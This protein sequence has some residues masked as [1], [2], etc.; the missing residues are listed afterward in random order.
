MT[1][2]ITWDDS[3]IPPEL[4][5]DLASVDAKESQQLQNEKARESQREE[6]MIKEK[7][8]ATQK[9]KGKT[10]ETAQDKDDTEKPK[11]KW[12]QKTSES[13]MVFEVGTSD[14]EA[15]PPA[16][17]VKRNKSIDD[18]GIIPVPPSCQQCTI[19]RI[20]CTPNGWSVACKNC[21]K[22]QRTCSLSKALQ[23]DK[24]KAKET[25]EDIEKPDDTE[26]PKTQRAR[27]IHTSIFAVTKPIP[28]GR[29]SSEDEDVDQLD[30]SP[31]KPSPKK[32]KVSSTTMGGFIPYDPKV[33]L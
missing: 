22:S 7:A 26:K 17:R 12:T 24:G 23:N 5:D 27:E 28:R 29:S 16:K 19:S 20:E 10:K 30:E 14:D 3:F 11:R 31:A 13:I 8:M 33:R 6:Q 4:Y 2:N 15:E 18:V 32:K 9:D 1:P 21:Q 25:A